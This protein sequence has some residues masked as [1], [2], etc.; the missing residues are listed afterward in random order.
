MKQTILSVIS[1]GVMLWAASDAVAALAFYK[2][3]YTEGTT[4]V[5]IYESYKGVH[6]ITIDAYKYCPRTI[7]V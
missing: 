4:K 2:R 3:E 6:A 7:E 5:C 1:G